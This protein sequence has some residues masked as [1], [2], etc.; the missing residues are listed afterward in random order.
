M[1]QKSRSSGRVVKEP[2]F[3]AD[4][5]T[6]VTRSLRY[7]HRDTRFFFTNGKKV[8]IASLE[9]DKWPFGTTIDDK[10][11][12]KPGDKFQIIL[13]GLPCDVTFLGRG[14][15][16]SASSFKTDAEKRIAKGLELRYLYS[17]GNNASQTSSKEPAD[18]NSMESQN[19]IQSQTLS[20]IL[21]PVSCQAEGGQ[22][23][24]RGWEATK[25]KRVEEKT[26]DLADPLSQNDGSDL[27]LFRQQPNVSTAPDNPT[28]RV[29]KAI[30]NYVFPILPFGCSL[31]VNLLNNV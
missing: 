17:E 21:A 25:K 20:Q 23:Q 12:L 15:A 27:L 3:E 19:D 22:S 13:K 4:P 14:N 18:R 8:A 5:E 26:A 16:K 30:F 10:L 2:N 1:A 24:P 6:Q 9:G 29:N 11:K 7:E 28:S 31:I